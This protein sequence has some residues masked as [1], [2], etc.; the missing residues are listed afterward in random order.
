M[1]W[2]KLR[3]ID[4]KLDSNRA[5]ILEQIGKVHENS[6]ITK[7]NIDASKNDVIKEINDLKEVDLML[8]IKIDNLDNKLNYIVESIQNLSLQL[9]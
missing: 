3:D 1:A 6:Q 9:D 2:I 4:A 8:E 7:N 5:N